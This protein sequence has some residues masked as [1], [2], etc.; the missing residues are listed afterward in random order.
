MPI[1]KTNILHLSDLHFGIESTEKIT[2]YALTC[3]KKVLSGLIKKIEGLNSVWKPDILVITGDIGWKGR[4]E[5]YE[6]ALKWIEKNIID[7][8]NI[9]RENII[10]IPGNHDIDVKKAEKCNLKM[11]ENLDEVE[12]QL[13]G[14]S[15]NDYLIPFCDYIKFCEK[16]NKNEPIVG[17]E[18]YKIIGYINIKKISFIILNSSWYFRNK[19]Q[20]NEKLWL[21]SPHIDLIEQNNLKND[22]REKN[23]GIVISL[24]H[25]PPLYLEKTESILDIERESTIHHISK[26]SNI[27]LTGHTHVVG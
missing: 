24:F 14:E 4:E 5:D 26:I 1:T 8:L 2:E 13:I 7:I 3:R 15:I 16:L 27:I 10:V 19:G 18:K 9:K 6:E 22:Y 12:K 25:H 11:A 17:K 20:N 21:G 23:D